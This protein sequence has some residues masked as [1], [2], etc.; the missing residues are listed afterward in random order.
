MNVVHTLSPA[1]T[2]LWKCGQLSMLVGTSMLASSTVVPRG[3]A[4]PDRFSLGTGNGS[5]R[6]GV[7]ANMV[8]MPRPMGS[9]MV[10]MHSALSCHSCSS[11]NSWSETSGRCT[12]LMV[13]D[14]EEPSMRRTS[15][16]AGPRATAAPAAPRPDPP[17][18]LRPRRAQR[19]PRCS[20]RRL[21]TA[22]PPTALSVPPA[23]AGIWWPARA[24]PP[25][26][27][28]ERIIID[29]ITSITI[30]IVI[31]IHDHLFLIL[32]TKGS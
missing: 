19:P 27:R 32:C 4:L 7:D 23:C 9:A 24:A 12:M 5:V 8:T 22:S 11:W 6:T 14:L 26:P 28:S 20:G 13:M 15:A 29:E 30:D 25:H 2:P 18:R 16:T 3:G 17:C 21:S 1:A 31:K 10:R